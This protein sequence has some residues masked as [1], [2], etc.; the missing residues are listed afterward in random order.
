L[1]G[2]QWVHGAGEPEKKDWLDV[3]KKILHAGKLAQ[4]YG[5]DGIAKILDRFSAASI[6]NQILVSAGGSIDDEERA[7]TM[8]RK[9]G[10]A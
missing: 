10:A 1:N 8:L 3:Y 2:V 6:C 5:L 7:I 9:Y 4:I